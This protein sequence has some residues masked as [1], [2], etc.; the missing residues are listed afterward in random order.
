MVPN[1]VTKD[2]VDSTILGVVESLEIFI[3]R[4]EYPFV[5]GLRR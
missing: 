5:V 3:S 1:V 2:E 4:T